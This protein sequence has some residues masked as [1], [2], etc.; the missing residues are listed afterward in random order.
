MDGL[1][2]RWKDSQ[3]DHAGAGSLNENQC[4]EITITGDEDPALIVGRG[5]QLKILRSGHA[6][7]CG[8]DDVVTK[9]LEEADRRGVDV[10]IGEEFLEREFLS[11]GG[12]VDFL[13]SQNIHGVLHAGTEVG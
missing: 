6:K 4:P 2:C 7:A 8:G 10:P 3:V 1:L 5:K 13:G 11:G 9:I 12:E